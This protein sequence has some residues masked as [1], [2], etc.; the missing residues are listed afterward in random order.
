MVFSWDAK[1]VG[2]STTTLALSADIRRVNL[3]RVEIGF[4]TGHFRWRM[5]E[6]LVKSGWMRTVLDGK[7]D[8]IPER[9]DQ[10]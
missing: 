1:F 5:K 8:I 4:G 9:G 2:D 7:Q 10:N 3:R 6:E